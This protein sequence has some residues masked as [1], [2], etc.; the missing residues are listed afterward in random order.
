MRKKII[1]Y[2]LIFMT[3]SLVALVC[4]VAFVKSQ[5]RS[6]SA[7]EFVIQRSTSPSAQEDI[8]TLKLPAAAETLDHTPKDQATQPKPERDQTR[9]SETL[10]L[11]QVFDPSVAFGFNVAEE[12]TKEAQKAEPVAAMPAAVQL[13]DP[14][15][16]IA[17]QQVS[18]TITIPFETEYQESDLLAQGEQA[19]IQQGYDALIEVDYEQTYK[20]GVLEDSREIG[21]RYLASGQPHIIM[22]GTGPVAT[23]PAL[24]LAQVQKA[25]PTEPEIQLEQAEQAEQVEQAASQASASGPVDIS[26]TS[27]GSIAAAETNFATVASLLNRNGAQTYS[28]FSDNGNGTITVDGHTF[29]VAD[30]PLTFKT[31]SYDGWECYKWYPDSG[32]INECNRTASG[33][34]AQ[35]GIVAACQGGY[36]MGTVLFVEGYGLAVVGDRHG[37]GPGLLDLAFDARE[38]SQNVFLPTGNRTVYVLQ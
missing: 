1:D 20:N 38:I 17:V 22:V 21:R 32:A 25:A 24:P 7:A 14:S 13:A 37:M 4:F 34:L 30:G 23:E 2:V 6:K 16:Q 29:A 26:F 5:E 11:R 31:T 8:V 33:I 28:S 15:P 27:P 9:T 12:P 36:P 18:E 19:V 35:R 3:F 10:D